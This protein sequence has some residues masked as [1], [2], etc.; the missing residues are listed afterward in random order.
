[1]SP[2]LA[3]LV[4]MRKTKRSERKD[5]EMRRNRREVRSIEVSLKKPE[6]VRE[7]W[8]RKRRGSEA[9]E[10]NF[11]VVFILYPTVICNILSLTEGFLTKTQ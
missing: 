9:V 1:M 5:R 10:G 11:G 3:G 6:Q 2:Q 8:E 7:E 4:G